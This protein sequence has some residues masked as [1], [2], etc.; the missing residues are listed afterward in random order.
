[1]VQ[2]TSKLT[3]EQVD[4]LKEPT[5]EHIEAVA[6]AA[7]TN[8]KEP[9][10]RTIECTAGGNETQGQAAALGALFGG[11]LCGPICGATGAAVGMALNSIE[12]DGPGGSIAPYM[13]A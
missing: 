2:V 4:T 1:M 12:S 8:L 13:A 9:D 7:E 5:P 3:G 10:Q 6:P 11:A